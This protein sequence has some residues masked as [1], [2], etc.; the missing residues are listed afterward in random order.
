[1]TVRLE[2]TVRSRECLS[3][4]VFDRKRQRFSVISL[5]QAIARAAVTFARSSIIRSSP[6]HGDRFDRHAFS[7]EVLNQDSGGAGPAFQVARAMP[8]RGIQ[9]RRS[10]FSRACAI[11]LTARS[12]IG[13]LASLRGRED[14]SK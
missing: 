11:R 14:S 2:S 10:S 9:S 12:S 13:R 4:T 1:M 6:E 5:E 7:A 3:H 8:R